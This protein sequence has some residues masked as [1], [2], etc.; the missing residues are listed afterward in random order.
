MSAPLQILLGLSLLALAGATAWARRDAA[1]P[2]VLVTALWGGLLTSFQ[3]LPHSMSPV[4]ME[5][6][7]LVTAAAV[8]FWLG[9]LARPRVRQ[10]PIRRDQ[11]DA[12]ALR[13]WLYGVALLGL[14][15]YVLRALDIAESANLTELWY[16]NLRI[17]LSFDEADFITYGPLA[18]LVPVAFASTLIELVCSKAVLFERKGWVMFVVA[19]SYA[20]LSTGRTYLLL[21]LVSVAFVLLAQRR[22]SLRR[23]AYAGVIGIGLI[24]FGIGILANK[25]A[26]DVVEG[27]NLTP[28]DALALYVLSPLAALDVALRAGISLD[29]GLN[30]LRTPLAVVKALGGDAVVVPLVKEYVFVPE[31][32]NVYTV[33]LPYLKDFGVAGAIAA[34]FAFGAGHTYLYEK[35]KAQD[36]RWIIACA[37]SLYPLAMQFFQDQYFSLLSTWVVYAVLIVPSFRRLRAAA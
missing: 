25:V 11:W 35:A 20:V 31:A 5:T 7:L 15:F 1:H 13:P 6:T 23:I 12:T 17:A 22:I 37:L 19:I 16:V 29:W 24:F 36:P 3:L 30:M 33:F 4:S 26:V 2:S 18:Y 27:V 34:L 14:P 9:C 8:S 10:T 32:T 21:L 28:F